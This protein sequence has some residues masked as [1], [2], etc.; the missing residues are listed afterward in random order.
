MCALQNCNQKY[1]RAKDTG[2]KNLRKHCIT[3]H[4]REWNAGRPTGGPLDRFVKSTA[5]DEHSPREHLVRWIVLEQMSFRTTESKYFRKSV[6][7][8]SH[9]NAVRML[10]IMLHRNVCEIVESFVPNHQTDDD[11]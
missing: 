6:E 8:R 1:S 7:R 4:A 3:K 10:T 9:M 5:V 11:P 2:T